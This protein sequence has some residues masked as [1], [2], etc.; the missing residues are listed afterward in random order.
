MARLGSAL[1]F[2]QHRRATDLG[3]AALELAR[4]SGSPT[5][6]S[7]AIRCRLRS[8]FDPDS[9]DERLGL[10]DELL[11]IGRVVPDAV[12][13]SWG[14]RW[15]TA[16]LFE[17]GNIAGIEEACAKLARLGA[18]LRLPNQQWSAANRLA[19]TCVLRGQFARADELFSIARTH[20]EGLDNELHLSATR[21]AATMMAWLRGTEHDPIA[22][23]ERPADDVSLLWIQH[24]PTRSLD[25][26][27]A[28][29]HRFFSNV[30]TRL[31][32]LCSLALTLRK[33]PRPDVA[34]ILYPRAAHDAHLVGTIAPA[35]AMF[36]SMHLYAGI[37]ARTAGMHDV[38]LAHLQRAIAVNTHMG[39]SPFVALTEHELAVSMGQ[40]KESR[41]HAAKA[42]Q[43]AV[44]G[45]IP[46]L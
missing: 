11:S 39:A 46:W 17:V 36:G 8:W 41:V 1:S 21:S 2:V 24:D 16:A 7:Y 18:E 31:G 43:L 19:A 9:V 37:I 4:S 15:R 34:T 32:D 44:A 13:E 28:E 20:A 40:S 23:R 42:H 35:A 22:L 33:H 6:L 3:V 14:W 26:L 10:A 27:A 12:T 25:L 45:G 5:D 30:I 29:P 38:A